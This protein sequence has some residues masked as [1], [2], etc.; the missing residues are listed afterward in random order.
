[1]LVLQL[2]FA[3]V[4]YNSKHAIWGSRITTSKTENYQVNTREKIIHFYQL[5]H[6]WPTDGKKIPDLLD[7]FVTNG[8]SSTYT[9]I[10]TSYDLHLD[11]SPITATLS[12]LVI[13]SKP[14]PRLHNTKTNW[15]TNRQI[16]QDEVNL[17][18]KLK[19]HGNI[20]L[21]VETNKLVNLLQHAAKK[22]PQ[23]LSPKKDK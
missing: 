9:D 10:Q 5:E 19:E 20:E 17:S 14:T 6:I 22:L 8:I 21:N 15:D 2:T 4:H 12:T 3:G 13:V 23:K 11:H 7:F 16:M 1:M 18:I